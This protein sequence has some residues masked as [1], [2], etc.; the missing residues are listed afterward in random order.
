MKYYLACCNDNGEC[1]G[2]LTENKT[3]CKDNMD[4]L[5]TFKK[6]ADAKE[7]CWQINF[8]YLLFSDGERFPFRVTPVRA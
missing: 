7:K 3:V 1:I 5:M 6:K 8:G 2:F 4:K